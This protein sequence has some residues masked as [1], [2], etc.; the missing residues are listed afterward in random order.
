MNIYKEL[1]RE[2]YP[3]GWEELFEDSTEAIKNTCSIIEKDKIDYT[4]IDSKVFNA[5]RAVR[6]KNVKVVIV[7]QDPY[8][9]R[10]CAEGLSFSCSTGAIP[11]SL[12]N[13][14]TELT[15]CIPGFVA[16]K[17]GDLSKWCK[18]GVM[19]L[20][21]SLVTKVG[22]SGYKP[23]IWMSLISAT[24]KLLT[25]LNNKIIWVLWGADAQ[26]LGKEIKGG[27]IKLESPHPSPLSAYRGFFGCK[28]FSTINILLAKQGKK[29]INWNL[30]DTVE[31]TIEE[32]YVDA[33]SETICSTVDTSSDST[34]E[35]SVDRSGD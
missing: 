30:V 32:E 24:V 2:G 33:S 9:T 34:T 6:P 11:K 3:K 29:P 13:I 17:N 8:P 28:H 12:V 5:Y 1:R 21:V 14:Y 27:G 20:N 4:P 26:K 10:G 15:S 19:L 25:E 22:M 31:E 35:E 23:Q 18:E 16:P 7:G